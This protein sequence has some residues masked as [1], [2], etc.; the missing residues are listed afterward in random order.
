MRQNAVHNIRHQ[1]DSTCKLELGTLIGV[2]SAEFLRS[3]ACTRRAALIC[4]ERPH[5]AWEQWRKDNLAGWEDRVDV[6]LGPG[7]YDV[8][9]L[10]RDPNRLSD[11]VRLDQPLLGEVAGLDVAH[12]HC[13]LGTD[14]LSLARM[15]SKSCLITL[16]TA[17]D[18]SVW[19]LPTV[20]HA[21][22]SNTKGKNFMLY[23]F[24]ISPSSANAAAAAPTVLAK[25]SF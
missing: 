3:E 20:Q 19:A 10:L 7:G 21:L 5:M 11:T 1:L 13:H 9:A 6:H 22:K 16:I 12:L 25:T 23:G 2:H 8:D 17:V 18:S 4:D 24:Y 14:T 15:P